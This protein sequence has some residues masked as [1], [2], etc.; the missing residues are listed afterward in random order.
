MKTIRASRTNLYFSALLIGA[1]LLLTP[2]L[3]LAVIPTP[4]TKLPESSMT[5]YNNVKGESATLVVTNNQREAIF[6]VKAAGAC[7]NT[8]FITTGCNYIPVVIPTLLV[9]K[10]EY[11][12]AVGGF[13]E[14]SPNQ[15]IYT[16]YN[17]T[18]TGYSM[19]SLPGNTFLQYG[20]VSHYGDYGQFCKYGA[21]TL[22]TYLDSLH[23]VYMF[24][25]TGAWDTVNLNGGLT[26]DTY[27][28]AAPGTFTTV[29]IN[30]GIG[31]STYNIVLGPY[32]VINLNANF[33][34]G[35]NNIYNL[36]Y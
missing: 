36:V 4:P 13:I 25:G 6:S 5:L 32:G 29:N 19:Y 31:N 3:T 15:G 30:S 7:G 27:S 33:A 2:A 24:T 34:A 23:S 17:A 22:S 26:Q 10:I 21:E 8:G 1:V 14:S 11:I 18:Y 9:P 35:A 28:V 12:F 20:C 16:D